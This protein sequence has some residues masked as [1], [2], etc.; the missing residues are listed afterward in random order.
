VCVFC[1]AIPATAAVGARLSAKQNSAARDKISKGETPAPAK[2]ILK[3]TL[4]LVVLL[5]ACSV[6]YHTVLFPIL[7]I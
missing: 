3:A 7:R 4:L 5:G 6:I 1:A 2:R